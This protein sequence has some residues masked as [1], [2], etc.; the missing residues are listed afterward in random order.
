VTEKPL[1]GNEIKE[2]PAKKNPKR[3]QE[4]QQHV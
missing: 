4:E 3:T 1:K 2:I